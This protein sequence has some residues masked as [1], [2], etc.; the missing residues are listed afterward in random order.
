MRL[1][2]E[3]GKSPRII[4]ADNGVGLPEARLKDPFARFGAHATDAG[5]S[6]GLGL[7]LVKKVVDAHQGTITVTSR[8]GEGTQFSIAL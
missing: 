8:E 1:E 3:P 5:P 4:V 6:A 2:A 7:A